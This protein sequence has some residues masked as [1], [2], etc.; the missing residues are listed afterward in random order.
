MTMQ[1][2]ERAKIIEACANSE[3]KVGVAALRLQ[4]STRQVRRLL[5]RFAETGVTGMISGRVGKPSNNRL[6][7][8]L[9]Q[10]AI[11]IVR[12]H[13]ADF[14]PT[15]ACEMLLERHDVVLSKETLRQLMIQAGL[16]APRSERQA[17]LHQPRERRACRGELVQIDGSRHEWFEQRGPACTLLVYVDDATSLIMQLHFADTESTASYFDATR[18]YIERHGKPK[19]FYSDRAAVFRSA[20]ANRRAPTQ[21]QRALDELRITLICA[22]SPQAKG[23]VERIN[24]TLQDRLV[25]QLRVDGID[26]IEAANAWCDQFV[27]K[28]NGR[29]GRVPRSELDLHTPLHTNEDL[30][31]ILVTCET[32]KI[33]TKLTVQHGARQYLLDDTPEMRALVGQTVTLHIYACG[34]VEL[35]ASGK[36]LIHSILERPPLARA[37]EVD[38]KELHHTVDGLTLPKPR[39]AR[40]YRSSQSAAAV[41]KGV[42]AA[43]ADAAQKRARS[44]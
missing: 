1:E 19:A 30:A 27:Q 33:S 20:A 25:K 41:A 9:A 17:A 6:E 40:H 26:N 42:T 16:R 11:K 29:Y 3:I 39:R 21:F 10:K 13:Y 37:I 24:R 44:G 18:Q 28:Y 31:L 36:V 38:N 34:N 2:L 4:I 15:L 12:E 35:R 23:R 22:K 32:R 5:Q 43:K 7:P 8:G 14:G